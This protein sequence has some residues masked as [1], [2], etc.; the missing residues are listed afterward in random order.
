M[1]LCVQVGAALRTGRRTKY[2]GVQVR[3]GTAYRYRKIVHSSMQ[4]DEGR[5]IRTAS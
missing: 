2:S 4:K 1:R 5:L 3:T